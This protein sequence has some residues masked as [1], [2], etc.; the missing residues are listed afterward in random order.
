MILVVLKFVLFFFDLVY[1]EFLVEGLL[2]HFS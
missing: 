2:V 1:G